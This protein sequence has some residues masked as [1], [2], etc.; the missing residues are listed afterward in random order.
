MKIQSRV[1][2]TTDKHFTERN[3][4]LLYFLLR[5]FELKKNIFSATGDTMIQSLRGPT[6]VDPLFVKM[7]YIRHV[8]Y[9]DKKSDHRANVSLTLFSASNRKF[10]KNVKAI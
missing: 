9:K 4:M 3:F 6:E 10:T 5:V 1:G 2:T 7:I 8:I